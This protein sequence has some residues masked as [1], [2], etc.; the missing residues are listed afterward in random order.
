M[1]KYTRNSDIAWLKLNWNV[2]IEDIKNE[3]NTIPKEK[4]VIHRPEDGHKD[5]YAVTLYG[6]GW[7]KTN[8]HWE[9]LKSK[10]KKKLTEVG[11]ICPKTMQWIYSL[12]YS[13]IDDIRFLIIKPGGFI[14]PHI[15]VPDQN[16]LEPVNISITW[17][18]GSQFIF[19]EK[20]KVPYHA[21]AAFILNIHYEHGVYNNSDEDRI[22]LLIH[23][24]KK[25]EFWDCVI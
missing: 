22:H 25:E 2:P 16:W 20:G 14:K 5:W 15:D 12:P 17:P 4:I 6:Y 3:C 19:T 18:K 1:K 24:K 10:Q 7:D 9:Y 23:G 13:R 21:G 8:S 11:K